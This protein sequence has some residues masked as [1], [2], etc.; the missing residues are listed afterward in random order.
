MRNPGLRNVPSSM[1]SRHKVRADAQV[2][3]LPYLCSS[4]LPY[5]AEAVGKET[6]EGERVVEEREWMALSSEQMWEEA[7][8]VLPSRNS[9]HKPGSF[10]VVL[11]A[12]PCD[13][14]PG[15]GAGSLGMHA[16]SV[17][18][19]EGTAACGLGEPGKALRASS[20]SASVPAA[21]RAWL[22]LCPR[23]PQPWST[24]LSTYS[25]CSCTRAQRQPETS[26]GLALPG[27]IW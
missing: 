21:R 23:G 3:H 27:A 7:E 8:E 4:P 16:H 26:H 22:C 13:G 11:A 10:R 25:S 24:W 12:L 20:L 1:V 19:K 15:R 6:N 2:S 18:S 17:R 5:Q 14:Q 9:S